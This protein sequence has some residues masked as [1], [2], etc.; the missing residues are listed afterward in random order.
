MKGWLE[1]TFRLAENGT[2]VRRELLG[3]A[4]TF[5]TMSYIIFVQPAVLGTTGMDKGAVMVATCLASALATL[6][7]GLLARYPIAQAPAMGHNIFFAVVVCGTMGYS[8]QVALGANF[9]S[10]LLFVVLAL[11]GVWGKMVAAVPDALK[12]GIAVGIGLL[13]ALIGLEYGGIVVD[14]P[15]VLVALGDLGSR[16]VL[17]VLFG[18]ALTAVLLAVRFPGAILA[19][20]LVTAAAGLPL[21]IVKFRGVVA[22]VPSLAPTFLKLDIAGAVETGLVA[23]IFVFFLL[24]VFD[25]IGTLIGVGGSGGFLKDGK[26]PRADKAMLAD[27]VGTVGG[28][29]LG[30]ST[31][32]SYIE[33][34]T[35][36]AQGARTGL[37]NVMTS[38]LFLCA[39]FFSPLAE[40]ISGEVT[41][42]G[43]T[44][45]PVIAPALILVGSMMMRCVKFI[46]WDDLTEAIP[47]FLS[48]V[49]MPL[50][51]SITEGISF[52]FI[53]YVLLKLVSGK[54][55]QVH[56]LIYLFA[57][58]F[59]VRYII[60]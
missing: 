44:L 25:A 40:M 26:L 17:L 56:G 50:T 7:T 14:S 6:L 19:G 41:H 28:V 42:G 8:W 53:S 16:P 9:L 45:R 34:V 11:A 60:K 51:L 3:G 12:Y 35:G 10:G 57:A 21:G 38:A 5:M 52:G 32:S 24:D 43:M 20:I 59:I 55:R 58:L 27:A 31:V 47:A 36:I 37:A 4:T 39:L 1:R 46:N 18:L 15:G 29:L 30:T 33:S 22:P 48:I 54:G 2:T 49:I 13:I 23:V